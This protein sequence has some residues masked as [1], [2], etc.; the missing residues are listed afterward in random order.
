MM[1]AQLLML[2]GLLSPFPGTSADPA[3]A[4][5]QVTGNVAQAVAG[6]REQ[7]PAITQFT[8][9]NGISLDDRKEDVLRKKGKPREVSEDWLLHSTEYHYAD[10]V[11]GIR[12]GYVYYVHVDPGA[13]RVQVNDQWLPLD[14]RTLEQ[15][16]G[17]TQFTAEDGDVYVRG[18]KAIKVYT[19]PATGGLRAVELF[20]E[21][22]Q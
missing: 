12:D 22:S 10:A 7:S 13:M 21:S 11:V 1:I 6:V 4:S 17:G 15:K 2:A 3:A 19:N 8:S 14:R 9:L 5:P 20:D 16:L 18:H